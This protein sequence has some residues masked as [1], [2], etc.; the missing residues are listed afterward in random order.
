MREISAEQILLEL[1]DEWLTK[2]HGPVSDAECLTEGCDGVPA[3]ETPPHGQSSTG[4]AADRSCSTTEEAAVEGFGS[5]VESAVPATGSGRFGQAFLGLTYI[6]ES[7]FSGATGAE[8]RIGEVC[9]I[10]ARRRL[11]DT[12][13]H[14]WQPLRAVSSE[15][16]DEGAA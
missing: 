8:P 10:A 2:S 16:G 15:R 3:S 7:R 9:R 12:H 11:S 5:A 1:L 13:T 6:A 4:P 14:G